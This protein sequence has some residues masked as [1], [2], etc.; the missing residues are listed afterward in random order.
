MAIL[1][2]QLAQEI[3]WLH[4]AHPR[5]GF[6]RSQVVHL[7]LSAAS[8]RVAAARLAARRLLPRPADGARRAAPGVRVRLVRGSLLSLEAL[9]LGRFDYVN[10]VGVLHH[11][12]DPA[13][14]L[15]ALAAHALRPSGGLGLMVYGA[16]GRV[17]VYEAQAALRLLHATGNASDGGAAARGAARVA[18]AAALLAALPAAA[19][20]RRNAPVWNSQEAT[21]RMG[22]AGVFD[23]LLS[24][25]D[26]AYTAPRLRALAAAAGLR[27]ASWLHPSLYRPSAWV[28]PCTGAFAPCAAAP[29]LPELARRLEALPPQAAEEVAELI[30]GH[31]RKHWAFLVPRW[32]AD[33]AADGAPRAA[34]LTDA[35]LAPCPNNLSAATLAAVEA[36][37]GRPL[38]VSPRAAGPGRTSDR[39]PPTSPPQVRTELQGSPLTLRLPPLS[40]AI[41]RR[42]DCR[43]ALRDVRAAVLDERALGQGVTADAFDV[44]WAQLSSE[45]AGIGAL[46]LTDTWLPLPS[47]AEDGREEGG[48]RAAP[49]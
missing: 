19:P 22:D 33:A 39:S 26:T 10:C 35:R 3:A 23:L 48:P 15:R 6:N 5:C 14:A 29:P 43:A 38:Q 40:H 32:A 25:V 47:R 16:V 9:G 24:P 45:L 21:G 8:V 4:A 28:Q 49:L 30:G 11:L 46:A 1:Q 31:A 7:D 44:Q 12:P 20:L 37:A 36:H 17:G 42:L 34:P 41:L 2:V 18:D 13:A 27:V